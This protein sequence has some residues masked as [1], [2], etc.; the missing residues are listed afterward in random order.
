MAILSKSDS[1]RLNVLEEAISLMRKAA[2]QIPDGHPQAATIFEGLAFSLGC[3]FDHFN[4]Q[5]D[6]DEA[7]SNYSTA[8]RFTLAD[9]PS[10][11][12]RLNHLANALYLRFLKIGKDE[13]M[14]IS[15]SH[16]RKAVELVP[17]TDPGG[18]KLLCDLAKTL[19]HN[20]ER[21]DSQE[22]I[23]DVWE[24]LSA[25][26]IAT[27]LPMGPPTLRLQAARQW[28]TMAQSYDK[29]G[30]MTA[31]KHAIDLLPRIAWLG[32]SLSDQH[33][34]LAE[35]GDIVRDAV[36]VAILYGEYEI[37]IEWAEQGRSIVW[38]N[39]LGL[40]SPVDELRISH[41]GLADRLQ[42]I[43]R[44]IE[45]PQSLND[46]SEETNVV[47]TEDVAQRSSQLAIEWENTIEEIRK[48]PKFASFLEAKSFSELAPVSHEGPVVVLNVQRSRCDALILTSDEIK[49]HMHVPLVHFTSE[50]SESLF[51]DMKKLLSV[52]GVRARGNRKSQRVKSSISNSEKFEKILGELWVRVVKPVIDCLG[53]PVNLENPP[54]IWWCT[55]GFLSFLPIHAAGLYK[56]G[57]VGDKVTDY[58]VSSYT[59][60]LTAIL[61]QHQP[62]I[63]RDFRI[64]TVA[65]PKTPYASPLPNTEDEVNRIEHLAGNISLEKLTGEGATKDCVLQAMKR[66]HWVH[67]A[68][69][70]QQDISDPMKSGLLLHDKML[71]LSEL[72]QHSFPN[73]DFAFLSACQTGMGDEK[74][75]E[76]SAHLAAGMFLAGFRGV[77]ATMW[78]INDADA[79]QVAE[80]VYRRMLKG[81][82]PRRKEAAY[83]LHEAVKNLRESGADYISWV[84]FIHFGR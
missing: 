39:L 81:G 58:V 43:S 2:K 15:L 21:S 66:S 54:R 16:H 55:S 19:V 44:K 10:L 6:L 68:C 32:L 53:Y 27:A 73:S 74:V 23:K 61:D 40:R 59:P 5:V 50:L 14:E 77:I 46:I 28:A 80:D 37:A 17:Q 45:S 30:T 82:K 34:L 62:V 29:G 84:P 7:I 60:T 75:A 11:P 36:G 67:L 70:G 38:Q 3:R 42:N 41:S 9:H 69:H 48:I 18:T 26:S 47:P 65:Q 13:D 1:S 72:V 71:E 57:G 51:V 4:I 56:T 79:P 31:L 8:I 33:T 52:A 83:A 78:S 76:E 63:P 24:A 35:F 64:L 25:I 49:Q 20:F 22:D 12:F